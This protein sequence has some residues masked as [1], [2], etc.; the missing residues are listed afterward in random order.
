MFKTIVLAITCLNVFGCVTKNVC[1]N[2]SENLRSVYDVNN[3]CRVRIKQVVIGSEANIPKSID[4]KSGIAW[5]YQWQESKFENGKLTGGHFVLLP[6]SSG[7]QE[8]GKSNE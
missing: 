7:R 2:Q 1:Q 6:Q 5:T 3:S 8:N 4:F